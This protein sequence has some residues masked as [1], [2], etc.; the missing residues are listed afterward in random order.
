[1]I[2]ITQAIGSIVEKSLSQ[3]SVFINK[4]RETHDQNAASLKAELEQFVKSQPTK[5]TT[6]TDPEMTLNK[7]E[8]STWSHV[9]FQ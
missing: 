8:L 5:P 3:L 7:A 1:M 4:A 6:T 9:Y 2:K